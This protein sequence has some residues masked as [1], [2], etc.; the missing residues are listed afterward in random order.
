MVSLFIPTEENINLCKQSR[1]IFAGSTLVAIF[2]CFMFLCDNHL[3]NTVN[4][5]YLKVLGTGYIALR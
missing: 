3:L 1:F 5:N 4:S 2:D